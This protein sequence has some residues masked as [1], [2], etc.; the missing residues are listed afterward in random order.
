FGMSV[1][2]LLATVPFFVAR[3]AARILRRDPRGIRPV[4]A[5]AWVMAVVSAFGVAFVLAIPL[6]SNQLATGDASIASVT[7]G[8]ISALS[9]V[10]FQVWT[11]VVLRKYKVEVAE[12]IAATA[13]AEAAA[14]LKSKPTD[15]S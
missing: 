4:Y 7:R 13:R 5:W 2:T 9:S 10:A 11:I 1:A 3:G 8:V 6:F 15:L 14:S 12:E